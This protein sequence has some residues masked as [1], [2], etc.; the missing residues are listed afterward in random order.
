MMWRP[1]RVTRAPNAE[2]VSIRHLHPVIAAPGARE[3][4][5]RAHRDDALATI[6]RMRTPDEVQ[7]DATL[8]VGIA[9]NVLG[10]RRGSRQ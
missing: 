4:R 1:S 3:R 2:P 10:H 7:A 6:S 5:D 8:V 9:A